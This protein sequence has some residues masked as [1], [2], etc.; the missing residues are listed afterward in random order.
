[1]V[2]LKRVVKTIALKF[3]HLFLIKF[4]QKIIFASFFFMINLNLNV[5]P[6]VSRRRLLMWKDMWD[7]TYFNSEFAKIVGPDRQNEAGTSM[8]STCDGLDDRCKNGRCSAYVG[9]F[10]HRLSDGPFFHWSSDVPAGNFRNRFPIFIINKQL[11]K[12]AS[13]MWPIKFVQA[14]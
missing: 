12:A 5:K 13:H 11:T 1:M 9:T 14:A 2:N 3:F 7:L 4:F 8:L 6:P 10:L